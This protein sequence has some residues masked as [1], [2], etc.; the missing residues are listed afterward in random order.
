MQ[1]KSKVIAI[2]I[3]VDTSNSMIGEKSQQV[4]TAL[5]NFK[6]RLHEINLDYP[7]A[8]VEISIL[9]FADKATWVAK[10]QSPE[11][12][13][14][15]MPYGTY[16]CMGKAFMELK[17]E[18]SKKSVIDNNRNI[19]IILLTDGLPTD[20]A[21]TALIDLENNSCFLS[22]YR[23]AYALGNDVDRECLHDF[24]GKSRN[25]L[26]RFDLSKVEVVLEELLYD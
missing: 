5:E 18:L 14:W 10:K 26:E 22:C 7:E 4:E 11:D 23:F 17:K 13:F 6:E 9:C 1:S 3:L 19:L 25:V 2:Y 8:K 21:E 24:T 15:E 20:D 16:T 12:L